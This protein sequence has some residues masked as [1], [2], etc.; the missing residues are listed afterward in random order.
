MAARWSI[1]VEWAQLDAG[2][3]EERAGFAALGIHAYEACLTFGYDSLLQS[4]RRAPYLSAYHFAEWLAWN[5]WRLRWEPHRQSADWELSHAMASIGGGYIWPN[6]HIVSDGKNVSLVSRPT[7]ERTR[8]PYRYLN[9]SVSIIPAT[10]FEGEIDLFIEAVL[11]RLQ[12]FEATNSNL[13]DIWKDVVQERQ[14]PTLSA[15]RKFEALLGEDPG[16]MDKGQLEGFIANAEATGQTAL[17]EIAAN[18]IPGKAVPDIPHLL[19]LGHTRGTVTNPRDRIT[20]HEPIPHDVDAPWRVG[21]RAAQ[22]LRAQESIDPGVAITN[23]Q[24]AHMYGAK[25]DIFDPLDQPA[26]LS[27]DLSESDQRHRVVLRRAGRETG[28]RFALARLLGDTLTHTTNDPV[29]PATHSDTY[30]QKVQRA[31][32][33]ELLSPFQAVDHILDGDYSTENQQEVAD[34]FQVSDRT[35][36]T[37]LVNNRRLDRSKLEEADWVQP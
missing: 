3:P 8:T 12:T 30:R 1:D 33:A 20:L 4:V 16:E 35:I 36:L 25:R 34:H 26:D 37:L 23:D 5:W 10:D 11:Q 21:T 22:L 14:D 6:I 27:F 9:D 19:E 15:Q 18:R 2:A 28:R 24:L 32:A 17:E 13:H 29:R 7:S 31:F